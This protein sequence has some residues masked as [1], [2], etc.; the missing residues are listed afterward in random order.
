M[1]GGGQFVGRWVGSRLGK[2]A[3]GGKEAHVQD[4][5]SRKAAK[6]RARRNMNGRKHQLIARCYMSSWHGTVQWYAIVRYT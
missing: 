5:R 6:G 3:G 4:K 1:V 2:V